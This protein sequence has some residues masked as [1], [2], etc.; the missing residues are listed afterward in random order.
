MS[1]YLVE[2]KDLTFKRGSRTIFKGL[3]LKVETGKITAIMGRL[4]S[5]KPLC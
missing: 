1:K 4:V 5:A 3:N 2:V